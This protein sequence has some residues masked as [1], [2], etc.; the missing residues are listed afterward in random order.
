MS[1]PQR[2]L[3]R[4]VMFLVVLGMVGTLLFPT[5]DTA[6][7]VNAPL[8][9]LILGV[10]VVGILYIFR[11]VIRLYREV[12]WLEAFRDGKEAPEPELLA[13]MAN[14]LADR[15]GEHIR[16]SALS[17]RSVLDGLSARLDESRE[18]SRYL[19]NLLI[20]LG[21]LG[22]FWG[23]LGTIHSVGAVI[24]GLRVEGGD[25]S[26]VF[27]NLQAGL[28][29]PLGG[30]GTAFS[31]SLFGLAGSLVLGFLEL[32]ASQAQNRFFQDVED[33]LSGAARLT[34]GSLTVSEGEQS[35]PAYLE[36]LLEQ[37]AENIDSLQRTMAQNEEGRRSTNTN[38]ADLADKLST[39]TD[40]MRAEQTLLLSLAESM[41]GFK[42]M[43]TRL[44]ETAS[45]G[46]FGID[47]ASRKHIRNIDAY[48]GRLV[49]EATSGR[50][51]AVQEVRGDIKL[52]ARTI[53]AIAEDNDQR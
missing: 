38:L 46:S 12:R 43:L 41:V 30:M 31:A 16:L 27:G 7:R 53:A 52:I 17:M 9:G 39:L 15:K 1:R 33:W 22:T 32:Q 36:A 23:L 40:Q 21:L 2:Y 19:I 26:A 10:L 28:A 48:L 50:D 13:P 4:M 47:E 3:N 42:P 11:Q 24:S 49:E 5:L 34:G 18:L 37:T 6:F 44:S 29:A 14:M 25:I 20:F 51:K 8:N 45:T 35:V